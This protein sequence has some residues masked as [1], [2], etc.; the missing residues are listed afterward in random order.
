MSR[1]RSR[2]RSPVCWSTTLISVPPV[3]MIACELHYGHSIRI[4]GSF[5]SDRPIK[6]GSGSARFP[7]ERAASQVWDTPY[8][9][10]TSFW[11]SFSM[12]MAV[13]MRRALFMAQFEQWFIPMSCDRVFLCPATTHCQPDCVSPTVSARLCQPDWEVEAAVLYVPHNVPLSG[14]FFFF[15]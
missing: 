6:P 13:M 4:R 3:S 9:W 2:W 1:V 5:P 10:A 12:V 7:R 8:R 15:G 14:Q 11:V